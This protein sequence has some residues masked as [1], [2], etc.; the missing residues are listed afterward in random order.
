MQVT[1]SLL[2][3]PEGAG[4]LTSPL[5]VSDAD[6]RQLASKTRTEFISLVFSCQAGDAS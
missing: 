1:G 5:Q 2:E 3:P 6:F 4:P